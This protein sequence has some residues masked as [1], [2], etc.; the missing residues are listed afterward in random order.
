VRVPGW[1][2]KFSTVTWF[3]VE[4]LAISLPAAGDGFAGISIFDMSVF[5]F[6]DA[7]C[8]VVDGVPELLLESAPLWL[9]AARNKL[10]KLVT[11]TSNNFFSR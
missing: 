2:E 4:G 8:A 10:S 5:E 3:R 7:V 6:V 9:H 11:V 1:N